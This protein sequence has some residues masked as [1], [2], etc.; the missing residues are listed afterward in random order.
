MNWLTITKADLYNSKVA[1]LI[2]AADTASLGQNQPD[3]STGVIAD[4][5]LEIR[6]RISKSNQLDQDSSKI[7]GGLKPLAV[8]LIYCRL[9][10]ALEIP[11][12]DDE[13]LFLKQREEQLDRIADGRDVNDP[14]DNPVAANPV[15]TLPQPAFGRGRP[16]EF[17]R[18]NQDG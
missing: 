3:R 2:D 11:L 4:V 12:S 5:T 16:R 8:D 14:A 7:P 15:Q 6:R 1:A 13:R 18:R 10:N 17:T 9:K